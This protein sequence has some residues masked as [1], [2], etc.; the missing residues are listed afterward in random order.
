MKRTLLFFTAAILMIS[1]A[2][3][4][5]KDNT[6]NQQRVLKAQ[7]TIMPVE[8]AA[9]DGLDRAYFASGCFWCVEAVYESLKGVKESISGYSGG[10][11][12]NP[13]YASSN[14][15]RTGHA[16]AVEILYDQTIISYKTLLEIFFSTHNPTTLNKQGNDIGTQY[17]SA[18]YCVNEEE[19]KLAKI[20][21]NELSDKKIFLDTIVTEINMLTRFY[22]AEIEHKD[23]YNLN[24]NQP[25]CA[26]IISP[27]I[28]KLME[29]NKEILK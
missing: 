29:Q 3:C 23:Y 10:H 24:S 18:I 15:G 1:G 27:K 5:S 20:Y 12:Q 19:L 16:E 7:Q 25:Y 21:V 26:A 4:Q 14:T 8:V 17:R 6:S 9:I 11:T 13:T 2:S 22:K 28:K